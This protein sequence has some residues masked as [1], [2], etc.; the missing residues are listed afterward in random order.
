MGSAAV[1]SGGRAGAHAP[2]SGNGSRQHVAAI[3]V[4]RGKL[5]LGDED[6]RAL[7]MAVVGKSSTLEMTDAQR[8]KVRDHMQ[9]LMQDGAAARAPGGRDFEA[10]YKQATPQERKAWALWHQLHRDGQIVDRSAR[11]FGA[12]VKRQVGVQSVSWCTDRQLNQVIE[13][14]KQWVDRGEEPAAV[15]DEVGR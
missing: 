12:W 7:L 2:R 4:L 3:H 8:A 14:L 13:A 1:K 15:T 6:Y 11:A 9:G 10:R 5:G